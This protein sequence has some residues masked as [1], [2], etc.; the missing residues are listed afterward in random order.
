M[1][2]ELRVP[3]E[4]VRA[5]HEAVEVLE[6]GLVVD[7]GE[8]AHFEQED[9]FLLRRGGQ[10]VEREDVEELLF[11]HQ[12]LDLEPDAHA[13]ATHQSHDLVLLDLPNL[14]E[15]AFGHRVLQPRA[16]SSSVWRQ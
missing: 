13:E 12:R 16:R 11:V 1:L 3:Q 10:Q 8:A 5:V 6:Q 9:L 15:P 2:G 14:F 7:R 4:A